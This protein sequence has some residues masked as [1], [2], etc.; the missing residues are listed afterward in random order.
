VFVLEQI[1]GQVSIKNL[2]PDVKAKEK[3]CQRG[4]ALGEGGGTSFIQCVS[5]FPLEKPGKFHL[6]EGEG[7]KLDDFTGRI[8]C[9]TLELGLSYL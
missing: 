1:G 7:R 4:R 9:P 5:F 6:E 8:R 3:T 2:G